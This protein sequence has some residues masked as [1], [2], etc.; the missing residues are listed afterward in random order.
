M[1]V[2]VGVAPMAV[3]VPAPGDDVGAG[4]QYGDAP[5]S[6]SVSPHAGCSHGPAGISDPSERAPTT[7][8]L[9]QGAGS[10]AR[11]S[12]AS[13]SQTRE[14]PPASRWVARGSGVVI[15]TPG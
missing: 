10:Q 3:T 15:R 9:K 5:C 6:L 7:A 2:I 13:S 1:S 4:H 12:F 14:R 8:P 11:I